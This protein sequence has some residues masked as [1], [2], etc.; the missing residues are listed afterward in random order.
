[1][2]AILTIGIRRIHILVDLKSFYK[3]EYVK[4]NS[5]RI[6][7]IKLSSCAPWAMIDIQK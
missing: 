3:T 7:H 5:I 1:M 2:V 4:M 6:N